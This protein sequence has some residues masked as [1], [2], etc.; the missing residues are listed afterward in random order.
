MPAPTPKPIEKTEDL[1]ETVSKADF[2]ALQAAAT[3]REAELTKAMEDM[4]GV[5]TELR[6]RLKEFEQDKLKAGENE[7]ASSLATIMIGLD[8][9]AKARLENDLKAGDGKSVI[10]SITD[11]ILTTKL[12]PLQ[13]ELEKSNNEIAARDSLI[14]KLMIESPAKTAAA[15]HFR[16]HPTA[17]EIGVSRLT[18]FMKREGDKLVPNENAPFNGIDPETGDPFTMG[19]LAAYIASS[20]TLLAKGNSL[21][22]PGGNGENTD[23]HNSQAARFKNARKTKDWD[24]VVDDMVDEMTSDAE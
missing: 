14:D 4:T 19:S 7:L 9:D 12:T 15:L 13:Q 8:E 5:T 22:T 20:D 16:D 11:H 23:E 2:D 17:Q 21:S 10:G 3:A 24:N 6:G 1:P 18:S